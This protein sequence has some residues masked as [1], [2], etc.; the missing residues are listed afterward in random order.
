MFGAVFFT[1]LR[2]AATSRKP[3]VLMWEEELAGLDRRSSWDCDRRPAA[4]MSL[5][6]MAKRLDLGGQPVPRQ[7]CYAMQSESNNLR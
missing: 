3:N 2:G 7:T 5:N 6:W 4:L 1:A